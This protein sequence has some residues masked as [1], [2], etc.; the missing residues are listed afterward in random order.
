MGLGKQ[1]RL[2]RIFANPSGNLCSVAID[3][4]IGYQAG[5]PAGLQNLGATLEAVMAG[6]PDAGN[7]AQ[8]Q[9]G[10]VVGALGGDGAADIAGQPGATGRFG[11]GAAGDGG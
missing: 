9:R 10:G 7:D 5:I 11:D 1:V 4:F 2:R 6:G 8:G 3:H